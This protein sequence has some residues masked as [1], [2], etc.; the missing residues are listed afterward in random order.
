MRTKEQ[1]NGILT[2]LER[3]YP[4]ADCTLTERD[5]W[6]LLVQVRLPR[7]APTRA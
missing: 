3:E 6:R 4:M 2:A 5:A 1:I 7:S